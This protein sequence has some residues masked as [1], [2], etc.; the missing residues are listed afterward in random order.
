MAAVRSVTHVSEEFI[1][2]VMQIIKIKRIKVQTKAE[3]CLFND[4]ASLH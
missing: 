2:T 3:A 1:R 4:N